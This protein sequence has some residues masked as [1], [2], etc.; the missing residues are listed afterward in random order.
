M[1]YVPRI[2]KLT[3]CL[4]HAANST[5]IPSLVRHRLQIPHQLSNDGT[6]SNISGNSLR[7]TALHSQVAVWDQRDTEGRSLLRVA[8]GSVH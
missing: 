6:A 2:E 7:R 1:A 4:F 5:P 3:C 8:E